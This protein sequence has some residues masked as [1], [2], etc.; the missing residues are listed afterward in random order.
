MQNLAFAAITDLLRGL[1]FHT[2]RTNDVKYFK[3]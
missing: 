2:E 1:Q 3:D